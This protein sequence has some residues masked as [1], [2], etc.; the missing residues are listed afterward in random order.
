MILLVGMGRLRLVRHF[1]GRSEERR[2]HF[3]CKVY[4]YLPLC[5]SLRSSP[6]VVAVWDYDK[7]EFNN[8]S[9]VYFATRLVDGA[10]HPP[11]VVDEDDEGPLLNST[12]LNAPPSNKTSTSGSLS[13]SPTLLSAL[14]R[15]AQYVVVKKVCDYVE[16][17]LQALEYNW[18]MAH[19]EV[20]VQ[21]PKKFLRFHTSSSS[22][23][24]DVPPSPPPIVRLIEVNARQHNAEFAPLCQACV[25]YNKIDVCAGAYLGEEDAEEGG[26]GGGVDF[27]EEGEDEDQ[28]ED[29][30]DGDDERKGKRKSNR[31]KQA[32]RWDMVPSRPTL[33]SPGRIVHIVSSV[34]GRVTRVN[35]IERIKKM[36]SVVKVELYEDCNEGE[37]IQ[38]TVDI[39]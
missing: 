16:S 23:R 27:A 20:K 19:T 5:S 36:S 32:L 26:G 28:E 30:E 14:P 38:K 17:A 25:G 2:W 15:R 39:R 13:P 22:Y 24:S 21:L 9:F 8:A 7:R 11:V 1:Y 3:I 35:H 33:L 29:G 31:I 10:F 6:Q 4:I 12:N 18:G 37:V 34:S